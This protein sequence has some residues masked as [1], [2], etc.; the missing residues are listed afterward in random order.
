MFLL[1]FLLW[2]WI[3]L[4]FGIWITCL[5]ESSL[6][7]HAMHVVAA[8][9]PQTSQKICMMFKR[10]SYPQYL[11]VDAYLLDW[12]LHCDRPDGSKIELVRLST[13]QLG[14]AF[15]ENFPNSMFWDRLWGHF[16][17][18]ICSSWQAGFWFNLAR[19][20]ASNIWSGNRT[21]RIFLH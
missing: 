3:T 10:N 14:G 4:R 2:C 13:W 7:E 16:W 21:S 6:E 19:P 1:W 12:C 18:L 15:G 9:T 20:H 5:P 17:T 8:K 11:L